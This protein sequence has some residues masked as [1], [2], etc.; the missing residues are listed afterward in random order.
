MVRSLMP[1]GVEH[2]LP[3]FDIACCVTVHTL[4]SRGSGFAGEVSG[5]G[6]GDEGKHVVVLLTAGFDGRQHSFDKAAASGA[7]RAEG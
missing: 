3:G 2:T 7:L 6:C 1:S 5:D 4:G